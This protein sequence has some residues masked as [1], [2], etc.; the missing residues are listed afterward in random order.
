MSEKIFFNGNYSNINNE[1]NA[2]VKVINLLPD[3]S[4]SMTAWRIAKF[5]EHFL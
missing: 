1:P 4:Y 2:S 3:V 5:Q